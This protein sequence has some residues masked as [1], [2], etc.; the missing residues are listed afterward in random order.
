MKIKTPIK[1]MEHD[2]D[3]EGNYG[4]NNEVNFSKCP[5]SHLKEDGSRLQ[6]RLAVE[7]VR[8]TG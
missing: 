8:L 3:D 2:N 1:N 6:F 7:F 5:V 4:L